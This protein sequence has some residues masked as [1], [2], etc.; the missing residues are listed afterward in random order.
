MAR[1]LTRAEKAKKKKAEAKALFN[2]TKNE[3]LRAGQKGMTLKQRQADDQTTSR[4]KLIK[5]GGGNNVNKKI[6]RMKKSVSQ[7]TGTSSK[8]ID[9][10]KASTSA[11]LGRVQGAAAG[12]GNW[13]KNKFTDD[14]GLSSLWYKKKKK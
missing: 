14:K 7:Q 1:T 2:K 5:Q 11:N 4:T 10:L 12:A 13:L 3:Q 6:E 8:N 9:K